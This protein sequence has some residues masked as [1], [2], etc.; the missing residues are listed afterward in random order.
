ME[1]YLLH[2]DV[3]AVRKCRLPIEIMA[4]VVIG[5]SIV[6]L[7]PIAQRVLHLNI[8]FY[9]IND[10]ISHQARLFWLDSNWMVMYSIR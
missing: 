4:W 10:L 7:F 6:Q 9:P 3:V 5:V 8:I 2:N 1:E